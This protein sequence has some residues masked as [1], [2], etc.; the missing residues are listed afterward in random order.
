MKVFRRERSREATGR[1]FKHAPTSKGC[2]DCCT[3]TGPWHKTTERWTRG[4]YICVFSWL[5]AVTSA[6]S[7]DITFTNLPNP[8]IEPRSPALQ[9]DPLPTELQGKP[10]KDQNKVIKK[11]FLRVSLLSVTLRN[12]GEGA[13]VLESAGRRGVEPVW[14]HGN[15]RRFLCLVDVAPGPHVQR[16]PCLRLP[17]TF[18]SPGQTESIT[19]ETNDVHRKLPSSLHTIGGKT[20][21]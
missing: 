19:P 8:G 4:L 7:S 17:F 20:M 12:G 18:S 3:I 14:V 13:R 2:G 21:L 11:S 9:A 15:P 10:T 5:K 6:V 1:L 16:A